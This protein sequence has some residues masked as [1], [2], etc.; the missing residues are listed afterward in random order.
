MSCALNAAFMALMNAG[1]PLSCLAGA[2]SCYLLNDGS[3]S[4][5]GA[6]SSDK[7]FD[8]LPKI[9]VY[10]NLEFILSISQLGLVSVLG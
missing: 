2:V 9:P 1:I 10:R 6:V 5:D 4:C 8:I 7:V 3:I